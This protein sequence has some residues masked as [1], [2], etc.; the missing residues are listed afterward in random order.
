[1]GKAPE[2]IHAIQHYRS[3]HPTVVYIYYNYNT[4][5]EHTNIKLRKRV[6]ANCLDIRAGKQ[7]GQK[8]P[9]AR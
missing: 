5:I 2:K 3:L 1:M 6:I 4:K 9:V 8:F 7:G